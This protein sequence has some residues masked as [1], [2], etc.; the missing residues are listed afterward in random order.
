MIEVQPLGA[1]AEVVQRAVGTHAVVVR[2][3]IVCGDAG[4]ELVGAKRGGAGRKRRLDAEIA[5]VE[6]GLVGIEA[7]GHRLNIGSKDGRDD[8]ILEGGEDVAD[9]AHVGHA[10]LRSAVFEPLGGVEVA[11]TKM[12]KEATQRK[13]KKSYFITMT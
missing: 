4:E 8:A 10:V 1:E 3:V 9:A 12:L 13:E 6:E 2:H 5:A 7:V 11:A